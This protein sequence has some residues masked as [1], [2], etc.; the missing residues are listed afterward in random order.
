MKKLYIMMVMFAAPACG[1]SDNTLL[2]EKGH[3]QTQIFEI[4]NIL[5]K[6]VN[7]NIEVE[8][9]CPSIIF[10]KRDSREIISTTDLCLINIPGYREFHALKDFAFIE[11]NNYRLQTPSTILY[12]IDLAILKGSAF[13]VTCRIQINNHSIFPAYCQKIE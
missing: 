12:D 8:D 4:G 9:K 11:Y 3:Q 5:A 13:E 7:R 6:V 2:N 10:F 1:L